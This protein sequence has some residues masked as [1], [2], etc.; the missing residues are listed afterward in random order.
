MVL[1]GLGSAHVLGA[2]ALMFLGRMSGQLILESVSFLFLVIIADRKQSRVCGIALAVYAAFGIATSA[3]IITNESYFFSDS[4]EF[5][6]P[7]MWMLSAATVFSFFAAIMFSMAAKHFHRAARNRVIWWNVFIP[8]AVSIVLIGFWFMFVEK[9]GGFLPENSPEIAT[10]VLV[11]SGAFLVL[12]L[13]AWRN[14]PG[15]R[16]YPAI[17][18]ADEKTDE[19]RFD[20]SADTP[21][22]F[23]LLV[24]V[25]GT[26]DG[27]FVV[28]PS[29]IY[30]KFYYL[31]DQQF[32]TYLDQLRKLDRKEYWAYSSILPL[33]LWGLWDLFLGQTYWISVTAGVLVIL[34]AIPIRKRLKNFD[35][36]FRAKFPDAPI[37]QI[38]DRRKENAMF[39]RGVGLTSS[40]GFMLFLVGASVF[41]LFHGVVELTRE[42]VNWQY[43][44]VFLICLLINLL[45]L[46]A[47]L[48]AKRQFRKQFGRPLTVPNLWAA[49]SGE[50]PR[51]SD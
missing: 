23:L 35:K 4:H 38:P 18:S 14:L 36:S 7:I 27:G 11:R 45:L 13:A 44:L 29:G 34:S 46:R 51:V 43:V 8:S 25:Q 9:T 15:T 10:R 48:S 50:I 28:S 42:I 5:Y 21:T 12:A 22:L 19:I 6:R 30:G 47:P 49:R 3:M 20:S 40:I 37:L 31:A 32:E 17:I 16:G 26:K 2:I 24:L 39:T 1:Y 33:V 41:S